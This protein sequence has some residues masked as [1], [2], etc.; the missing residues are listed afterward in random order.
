MANK[1]LA[2]GL[3]ATCLGSYM[4]T[5][6]HAF[7]ED[8]EVYFYPQKKWAVKT[9]KP[10]SKIC[11]I[12]NQFNNGF[13]LKFIGNAKGYSNLNIDLRQKSFTA[14][15]DYTINFNIPGV[16]SADIPASAYKE[17]LLVADLRNNQELTD[18]L[19]AASVL[20]V[21]IQSNKFR[22]YLTGFAN[23]LNEF[24]TCTG[25]ASKEALAQNDAA[26]TLP[27]LKINETLAPPPPMEKTVE[28]EGVEK[29]QL[30]DL[31]G[32]TVE[33]SR[34]YMDKKLN[35]NQQ[36]YT[37]Q[38][39]QEMKNMPVE[40]KNETLLP[41][42]SAS[43]SSAIAPTDIKTE[44]K[45]DSEIENKPS[46]PLNEED[47]SEDTAITKSKITIP[48]VKVVKN[49][50]V[51]MNV[52]LTNAGIEKDQVSENEPSEGIAKTAEVEPAEDMM[53]ALESSAGTPSQS[54]DYIQMRNKVQELEGMISSLK[55][56]NNELTD[57]L[58]STLAD[59]KQEHLTVSSENWDLERATMKY[60]ESELQIK[61]LGRELQSQRT[62]CEMEK[63]DLEAMLFDPRV[64]E[65]QQLAKLATLENALKKAKEDL[66]IQQRTYEERI[67]LLE[68]Q[69]GG[70]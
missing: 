46:T 35:Q 70:H 16:A 54:D 65:Q 43:E 40:Q 5:A 64:T 67:R 53:P 48:A 23:A 33:A 36:S 55:R 18:A 1:F 68:K 4:L 39:A 63:K 15:Q 6:S 44:N 32:N 12:E 21:Q 61:K 17:N 20:D 66:V 19:K 50:P 8:P 51:K 13:I 47:Q 25:A 9:I 45:S 38:L 31:Y 24:D 30:D 22:L 42:P 62:Q 58:K 27:N 49:D 37:E 28:Q 57:E 56:E 14:K 60:N 3:L 7:A 2:F 59:A 69:S 11:S 52:D 10:E 29:A 41:P 26:P 34:A